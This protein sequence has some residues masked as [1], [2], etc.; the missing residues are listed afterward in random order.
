MFDP[1]AAASTQLIFIHSVSHLKDSN[2]K[3]ATG[4]LTIWYIVKLF[5]FGDSSFV[6]FDKKKSLYVRICIISEPHTSICKAKYIS[7]SQ[8][9]SQIEESLCKLSVI[10]KC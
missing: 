5:L 6:A 8:W 10:H 1:G 2:L 3:T 4:C 9:S 7:Q